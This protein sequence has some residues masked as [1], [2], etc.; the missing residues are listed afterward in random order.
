MTTRREQDSAPY[1]TLGVTAIDLSA[2]RIRIPS[3]I[4]SL[5]RTLFPSQ[6][7]TIEVKLIG[8][9]L[10][11][12]WDP[13]TEGDRQRSGVLQVGRVLRELVREDEVLVVSKSGGGVICI[14]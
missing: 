2:G 6:K 1:A 10:T 11:A 9:L 5:A 3:R 8:R 13:N 14:D 7:S 4:D 12:S